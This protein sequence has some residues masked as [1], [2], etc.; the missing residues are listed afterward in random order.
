MSNF[1]PSTDALA[2]RL[3][4]PELVAV[5]QQAE[6]DVR[7]AF[8]QLRTSTDRLTATMALAGNAIHLRGR[9]GQHH[10]ASEV[11]VERIVTEM[12]RD[13]WRVL[14]DRME[15][16]RLMS[17]KAWEE[18]DRKIEREEPPQITEAIVEGMAR[19]FAQSVP[20]ML[21]AAVKEVFEILRPPG[22][23]YRTNTE[24]EIGERVILERRLESGMWAGGKWHV[25]HRYSQELIAL[26]NV[27]EML[28]G[29]RPGADGRHYSALQ[30]RIQEIP[31]TEPCHGGTSLFGFRGYKNGALHLRFRR[32][33]LVRRLNAIAGGARL[34]PP[35]SAE[36]RP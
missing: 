20:E 8:R 21:E 10:D 19:G 24:Y 28:D 7:A 35:T 14:V 22:S 2:I 4:V 23:R 16:R 13:V 26:E 9:H 1:D 11:D 5:Y 30:A 15:L 25:D 6:A 17:I 36:C 31:R 34:K 33:D 29:K 12:R 27:L 18:L 32:M 3:S